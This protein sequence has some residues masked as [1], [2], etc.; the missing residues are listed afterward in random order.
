[1]RVIS[2]RSHRSPYLITQQH[3]MLTKELQVNRKITHQ[4]CLQ[5]VIIEMVHVWH[6]RS[7]A[8]YI[9]GS[10]KPVN[11][12]LDTGV[13]CSIKPWKNKRSSFYDWAWIELFFHKL[14]DTCT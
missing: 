12:D 2:V 1:M 8:F 9:L 11:R 5:A 6:V 3:N 4:A 7:H 10:I 13:A 14:L